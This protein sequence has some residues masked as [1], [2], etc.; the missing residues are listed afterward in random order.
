MLVV[1]DQAPG[2]VELWYPTQ[3][4][5]AHHV[6]SIRHLLVIALGIDA[7][8]EVQV[9]AVVVVQ[10]L[11]ELRHAFFGSRVLV[12]VVSFWGDLAE[13]RIAGTLLSRN[14]HNIR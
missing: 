12:L 3:H 4:R 1:I 14:L 9:D 13:H 7:A 6:D 8:G 5:P 2:L 10:K 11:D